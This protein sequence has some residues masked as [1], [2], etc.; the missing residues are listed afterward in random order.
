MLLA[1]TFFISIDGCLGGLGPV[2]ETLPKS[3]FVACRQFSL[4][5]IMVNG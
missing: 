5:G 2:V 4:L 1:L 3:L